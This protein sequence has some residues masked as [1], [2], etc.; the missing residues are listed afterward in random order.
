MTR[1]QIVT[2]GALVL[3]AA[4]LGYAVMQRPAPDGPLTAAARPLDGALAAQST[5]DWAA[6]EPALQ[7][8]LWQARGF[9]IGRAVFVT[10]PAAGFGIFDARGSASFQ[11]GEP[12]LIYAEPRGYGYG[13]K[14]EGVEEIAFDIDLQVLDSAGKLLADKPGLLRLGFLTRAHNRE[15][16][17]NLRYDLAGLGPGD[18][19]LRTTFRDV[20]GKGQASVTSEITI[21]AP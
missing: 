7:D 8:A 5:A 11:P 18:Y 1:S 17:A 2:L 6:Q 19:R 10:A 15:F 4:S 14:G 13:V 20:H 9:H 12:I 3:A 16:M 21:A